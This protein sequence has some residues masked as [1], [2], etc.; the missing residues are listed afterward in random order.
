M[1]FLAISGMVCAC[2]FGGALLGLLLRA[3]PPAHH[4][5]ADAKDIVKLAMGL[6]A[7]M[8]ALFLGLML[9]ATQ[10]AFR[11]QRNDIMQLSAH[12]IVLDRLLAQYGPATHAARDLLRRVVVSTLQQ[13][14]PE[15]RAQ[16]G[17]PLQLDPTASQAEGLSKQIQALSPQNDIQRSL[18]AQALSL[19]FTLGQMR[20]LML[21]Q[22][23][24]SMPRP[25]LIVLGVLVFWLTTL[26]CSFGLLAPPNATVIAVLF[27][28]A[29][30]VAGAIFLILEGN[31]PF[32][33]LL[34][35]PS[36]PL[37]TALEHLGQ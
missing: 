17:G 35:I 25:F 12:I 8:T 34:R 19:A 37:R 36:D 24:R 5:S 18:Q 33:G 4:L 20:W 3:V 6:L 30:S 21:V 28:C 31:Q 22:Q 2:V 1:S 27:I 26:F 32:E 15:N 9:A 16:P 10:S 11:E 7:T 13:M 23:G 14:W 29:L